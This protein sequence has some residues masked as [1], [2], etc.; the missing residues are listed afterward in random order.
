MR[1]RFVALILAVPTAAAAQQAPRAQLTVLNPA[2][3]SRVQVF[4]S[5]SDLALPV[6]PAA[7]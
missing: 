1:A 4:P 5:S 7:R 6:G 2:P 3:S